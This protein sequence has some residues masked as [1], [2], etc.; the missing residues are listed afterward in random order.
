MRGAAIGGERDFGALSIKPRIGVDLAY[1]KSIG[2]QISLPNVELEIDP[3]TYVRGFVELGLS[4]ETDN[5]MLNFTP[6]LFCE[7]NED[8]DADVCG[9]GATFDY[10]SLLAADGAQWS[11]GFD[12]EAIDDR[13]SASLKVAHSREIFDGVGVSKSSFG[14]TATGSLQVEQTVV[15]TW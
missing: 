8:E 15:I 3:A 9:F 2:S 1:A 6:R 14:A 13:Q 7:T 4:Q 11:V 5:G 10:G 12:Y